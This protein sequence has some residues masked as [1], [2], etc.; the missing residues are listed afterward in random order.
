MFN[1]FS[2]VWTPVAY[3][4]ELKGAGPLGVEVADER[5]VLFRDG[6][7][8]V[9]A[10][11]DA[12]PHR[13]ALLSQGK[14][15]DGCVRCPFHGWRFRGDGTNAAVPWNPEA[16]TEHLGARTLAAREL[17]GMLW[18]FTAA[19]V[20]PVTEPQPPDE[21][22]Q[23]GIHLDGESFVWN[24][25]WTR[26][27]ENMSD[28]SH[29]PF[30]HPKTIGRGMMPAGTPRLDF[31][32][33]EH[34][35]GMAW[36]VAVD[37]VKQTYSS[38]LRWPNVMLLRIPAGPNTLGICFAAIPIGGGRTRILQMGYRNFATSRLA[39]PVFRAINRKVLRED[40]GIVESQPQG[41]VPHA[42][43]ERSV[44][45]DVVGLW[46]RKRFH[47]TWRTQPAPA[48]ALIKERPTAEAGGEAA[49]Q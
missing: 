31:E 6:G 33:T 11:M 17:A 47:A 42:A 27:V 1:G 9:R 13:G 5:V 30:V 12:C 7:G 10:L 43:E 24:A 4:R 36:N 32:T 16:K 48:L 49:A 19:D 15:E 41:P 40:Q 44:R 23:P 14:V 21:V 39:D 8:V 28:D 18:V 26:V 25:H 3:A 22:V 2:G 20:V 35:W 46:F 34:P 29:L 45:T 38:E 37:G